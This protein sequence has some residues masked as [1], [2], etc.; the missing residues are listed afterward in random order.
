MTDNELPPEL[1]K[2]DRALRS[3]SIEPRGSLGPELVGRYV[4]GER[5]RPRSRVLR[6]TRRVLMGLAA[7]VAAVSTL[8]AARQG[9]LPP[10]DLLAQSRTVD[11]CC[12]DLDGGPDADDG[13]LVETV[14]GERVRKLVVYEDLD[15]SGG[16]SL[17]DRVRFTRRGNP[18]LT[19]TRD[20][21]LVSRQYC[22][23]DYDGGGAADD[24][25]LVLGSAAGDV[26]MA[27][28]FETRHSPLS[29]P[30]R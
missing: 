7:G 15:R 21:A 24:G 25:V 8:L 9:Y 27:A 19:A 2:L 6:P 18:T 10:L 22:C 30:L 16:W 13:V 23:Q 26:V 14:R 28:I 11:H 20:P 1:A 5:A 17:G 4:A 29:A 3:T 12:R